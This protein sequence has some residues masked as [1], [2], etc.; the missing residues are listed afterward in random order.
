MSFFNLA[1]VAQFG[2]EATGHK[3]IG[4]KVGMWGNICIGAVN[5]AA[6]GGPVGASIGAL[7]NLGTWWI[8]ETVFEKVYQCVTEHC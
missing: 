4:K 6:V 1:D 7:T 3:E 2:L 8:G 5:G